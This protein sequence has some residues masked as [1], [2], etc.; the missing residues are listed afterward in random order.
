MIRILDRLVVGT[1]LKLFAICVLIASPPLFVIGDIAENLDTYIDRGLSGT[2]VAWAYVYQLPLFIQWSF[3]IAALLACVFTVHSMTMHREIVAAKAGGI[4]FYRLVAPLILAGVALTVAALG[5]TEVV[6]RT[7]RIAA[8]ILRADT[9]GRSWR[10]DFVYRSEDGL[11]WQVK[12]LTAADGRMTEVVLERPPSAS[13]PGLHVMASGA[14]WNAEDGWTLASGY[15]RRLRSDSTEWATRFD[16]LQMPEITERPEELLEVPPEPD[17]MTYAEIDHLAEIIERT[18]GDA[19]ELL[20]KREQK[21]SIP[22]ATLVILLFG[23]PLATSSKRGGAAYG[24]GISLATVI[25]YLMLFRVA[26]ALGE[27]GALGPLTAAWIPN[28]VF[29]GA[30]ALALV[31]VRT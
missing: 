16:R 12:R 23:A 13:A 29:L 25:A 9:P 7:N 21:I 2:E 27:A 19:R 31:R 3:P 22:V 20:V 26:A 4:S 6:P 11:T 18:G 17:E 24:V 28:A 1:F 30:A 10:S 15:L 14:A 8:Q 5:L